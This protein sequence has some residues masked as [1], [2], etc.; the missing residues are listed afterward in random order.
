MD[1]KRKWEPRE[2]RMV[3]EYM[4][5]HYARYPYKMRVRLGSVPAELDLPGMDMEEYRM[6]G[7]WRRWADAV[8]FKPRQ[9]VIIEAAIRPDPGYVSKLQLYGRLFKHT[10]ELQSYAGRPVALELVYAI[11]D[12]VLLQLARE[13]GIKTVHFK[14]PWLDDY[15]RILWPRERRAPLSNKSDLK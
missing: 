2:I 13:A 12:D 8:V 6:A 4:A 10:P 5:L 3:S 14:A 15:L 11:R 9:V 7:Q 1:G